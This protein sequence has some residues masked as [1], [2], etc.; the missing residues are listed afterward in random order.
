M[1][2][3]GC[4]DGWKQHAK[5][6]YHESAAPTVA[7]ESMFLTAVVNAYEGQIMKTMDVPGAFMQA[8]QDDLV[9]V[10]FTEATVDKLLE[11]DEEMYLP[12]VTWEGNQKVMYVE[13]LRVLYGAIKAVKLFWERLTKHLVEDWGL[14]I[15]PYDSYVANKIIKGTSAQW[16]GMWMTKNIP[17]NGRGH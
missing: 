8:D 12:Y 4:T 9:H 11:I 14:T 7:T 2:V 17:S 3:P 10:Q 1:K 5:I 16:C 6:P 13:L 15:N